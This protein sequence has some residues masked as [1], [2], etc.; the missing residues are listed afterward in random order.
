M[1]C[2]ACNNTLETW[3]NR[4]LEQLSDGVRAHFPAVLTWKY[5][6]DQSVVTLLRSRILGNSSTEL[7]NMLEEVH[8]EEWLRKQLHYISDCQRHK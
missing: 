2:N 4:M 7:C 5:A 8:R 1:D 6:C 3:D